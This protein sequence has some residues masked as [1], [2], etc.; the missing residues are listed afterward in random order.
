MKLVRNWLS[1]LSDSKWVIWK[2]WCRC[3]CWRPT[4]CGRNEPICKRGLMKWPDGGSSGS[5]FIRGGDG[6][7]VAGDLG[8]GVVNFTFLLVNSTFDRFGG[9]CG[10][11]DQLASTNR[12]SWRNGK[13]SLTTLARVNQ[14]QILAEWHS[15]RQPWKLSTAQKITRRI[16]WPRSWWLVKC[17]LYAWLPLAEVQG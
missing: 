16:C 3:C 9:G 11:R 6:Q 5:C 14:W 2:I 8:P 4:N 10:G 13:D 15:W 1:H 12:L 7:V 17:H